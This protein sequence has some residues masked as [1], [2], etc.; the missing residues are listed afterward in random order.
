M[1]HDHLNRAMIKTIT[2]IWILC[3]I[4]VIRVVDF[5]NGGT[6]SERFFA[7]ESTYPKE[8]IEF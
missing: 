2:I 6:K 4:T 5:S 8:I 1:T 3:G 7:T